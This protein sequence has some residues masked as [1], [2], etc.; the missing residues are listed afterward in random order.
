MHDA[1]AVP[2]A[3]AV[4]GETQAPLPS[5]QPEGH[6]AAEQGVGTLPPVPADPDDP[7]VPAAEL[8]PPAPPV[9][10]VP[11]VPPADVPPVVP[12]VF[13]PPPPPGPVPPAPVVCPD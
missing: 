9:T 12:A 11:P 8:V 13:E 6:E 5:Q 2:H 3:A 7:P 4:G 1:P 10:I